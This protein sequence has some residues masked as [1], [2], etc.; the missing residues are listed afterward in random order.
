MPGQYLLSGFDGAIISLILG[1]SQEVDEKTGEVKQLSMEEAVFKALS[2][3]I[4]TLV[5]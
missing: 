4:L 2:Q 1:G 3:E 5:Q